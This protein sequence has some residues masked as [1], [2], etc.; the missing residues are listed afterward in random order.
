MSINTKHFYGEKIVRILQVYFFI[1]RISIVRNLDI[2]QNQI[3]E[4]ILF[5]ESVFN[6]F[7]HYCFAP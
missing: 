7:Y 2:R 1:G 3:S 6:H 4:S 5:F